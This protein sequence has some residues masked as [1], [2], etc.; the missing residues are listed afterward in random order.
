MGQKLHNFK[1]KPSLLEVW[2][3][4]LLLFIKGVD[5]ENFWAN[6]S[7]FILAYAISLARYH[8]FLNMTKGEHHTT[9]PSLSL[10]HGSKVL[11]TK[12]HIHYSSPV[13]AGAS[14]SITIRRKLAIYCP[15]YEVFVTQAHETEILVVF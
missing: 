11:L 10:S 12:G 4:Y 7:H 5:S 14:I 6:K 2:I 9:I 13:E 8:C 15:C 3:L 1:F